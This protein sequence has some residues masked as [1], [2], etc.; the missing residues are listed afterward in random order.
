MNKP[1]P[2]RDGAVRPDGKEI[3][4]LRVKKGWDQNE[5]AAKIGCSL[6]TVKSLEAG[7]CVFLYTISNVAEALGE[8]V[9]SLYKTRKPLSEKPACTD[10]AHGSIL[11]DG[12]FDE[13]DEGADLPIL[14]ERLR[15]A[16]HA[17]YIVSIIIIKP[18]KSIEIG[19]VMQMSDA[20]LLL[21]AFLETLLLPLGIKAIK[22]D[23]II[24]SDI[25]TI[26][27]FPRGDPQWI[28]TGDSVFENLRRIRL[29]DDGDAT[30][31]IQFRA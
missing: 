5:M 16:I 1:K 22:F 30:S 11:V 27:P 15:A 28:Y 29:P 17:N 20:Y 4:R 18:S 31:I 23:L 13:F 12:N 3:K 21:D 26:A 7:K 8:E 2:C 19:L 6:R 9:H 10:P 25:V 24:E 14:M